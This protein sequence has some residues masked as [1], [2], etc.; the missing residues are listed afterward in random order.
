MRGITNDDIYNQ[1]GIFLGTNLG[2][3]GAIDN[4]AIESITRVTAPSG[5]GVRDEAL[6]RFRESKDRDLVM[7]RA[8]RL[9]PFVD[10]E[11]RPTA[12]LRI[13]VPTHPGW[14]LLPPLPLWP[15][16]A[17]PTRPGHAPACEV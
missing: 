2:L 8:A 1:A 3:E 5:P 6:I 14:H 17:H 13:E 16:A 12:G 15:D 7:G 11:G 9:A 4:S 10:A